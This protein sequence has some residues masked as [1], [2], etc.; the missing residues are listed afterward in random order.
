MKTHNDTVTLIRIKKNCYN[1]LTREIFLF[2]HE[3]V[4]CMYRGGSYEYTPQTHSHS[5]LKFDYRYILYPYTRRRKV[6]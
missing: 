4:W 2:Y 5:L 1:Y 6:F 3:N